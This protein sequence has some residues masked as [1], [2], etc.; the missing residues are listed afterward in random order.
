VSD[1]DAVA[2]ALA[3]VPEIHHLFNCAGVTGA[4]G[5][6]RTLAVNVL[7]MRLVTDLALARMPDGGSITNVASVGAWGWEQSLGPVREFLTTVDAGLLRAWCG[8]HAGLLEPSAYPFSKQCVVVETLLRAAEVA[9]RRIRVNAV[10]PGLVD[11]PMLA[12]PA[13]AGPSFVPDF[14]LP[15]G[16]MSTAEE[17]AAALILLGGPEAGAVSGAVVPTDHGLTAQVR[18]GAV[19]SPFHNQNPQQRSTQ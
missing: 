17:Q 6:E 3:D 12:V 1:R 10:Q 18:V 19:P 9:P 8:E 15:F 14:P 2:A 11:T 5:P 7:G 4:A 16:R 13:V